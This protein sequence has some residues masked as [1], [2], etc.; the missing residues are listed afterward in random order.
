MAKVKLIC[1][2]CGGKLQETDEHHY[3][4]TCDAV[5]H[6]YDEVKIIRMKP[7]KTVIEG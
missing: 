1:G 7:R 4:E 3:C 6:E 2:D 5:A